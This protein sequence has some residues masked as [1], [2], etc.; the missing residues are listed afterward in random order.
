VSKILDARFIFWA[1]VVYEGSSQQTLIALVPE[2][3]QPFGPGL[4][5]F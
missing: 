4:L 2:F 5:S 1:A 3:F